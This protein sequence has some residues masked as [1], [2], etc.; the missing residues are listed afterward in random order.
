M[1]LDT[2]ECATDQEGSVLC[3]RLIN[4]DKS[5]SRRS[6][7]VEG[8]TAC[9]ELRGSYKCRCSTG[10]VWASATKTCTSKQIDGSGA[11]VYH[12]VVNV[13]AM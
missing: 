7:V 2:P 9:I 5:A 12:H 3:N 11:P 13:T 4:A 8:A 6:S 1:C 10:F